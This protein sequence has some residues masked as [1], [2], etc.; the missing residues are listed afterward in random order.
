ML[1][2]NS[3]LNSMLTQDN[4]LSLTVKNLIC[5]R[6]Y[7]ENPILPHHY[8]FRHNLLMPEY[9]VL[10][11][12]GN[13]MKIK[14]VI[15]TYHLTFFTTTWTSPFEEAKSDPELEDATTTSVDE[16]DGSPGGEILPIAESVT[17]RLSFIC[18]SYSKSSKK[19]YLLILLLL[20]T[21]IQLMNLI[22]K[23]QIEII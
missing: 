18:Q 2:L 15:T 16:T 10:S 4:Q 5:P 20:T 7:L 1:T 12:R 3:S 13:Q 8:H 21:L 19:L 11:N 23:G 22:K 14:K 6:N 17:N 9:F